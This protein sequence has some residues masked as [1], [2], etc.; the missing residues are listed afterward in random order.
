MK[1]HI[2]NVLT[3]VFLAAL[4][5]STLNGQVSTEV[6]KQGQKEKQV[7]EVKKKKIIRGPFHGTIVAV[8][9]KAQTIT[10]RGAKKRVFQITSKTKILKDGKAAKFENAKVGEKVGGYYRGIDKGIYQLVTLRIGPKPVE[11]KEESKKTK[12][13]S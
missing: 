11:K 1:K 9:K 7:E 13:K 10:L 3:A 8:D 4:T 5:S 2:I 12:D 6:E